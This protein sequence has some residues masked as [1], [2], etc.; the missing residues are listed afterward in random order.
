[1]LRSTGEAAH[2][3][4]QRLRCGGVLTQ[5]PGHEE[6]RRSSNL[7]RVLIPLDGC[8]L[9]AVHVL[10]KRW[11]QLRHDAR[12]ATEPA[13][14]VMRRMH[15]RNCLA[16]AFVLAAG[17]VAG[18]DA[19]PLVRAQ[20]ASDLVC[21]ESSIEVQRSLDGSYRAVGCGKHREYFTVCEGTRCAVSRA[22]E[23]FRSPPRLEAIESR[24]FEGQ[25]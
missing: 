11:L 22:G 13:C 9:G 2:R 5:D 23:P 24:A 17:C 16:A 6:R 25:P 21:G 10:G 15:A 12:F 19:T 20:A 4:D 8:T 3:D 7:E 1:M 14:A 18:T